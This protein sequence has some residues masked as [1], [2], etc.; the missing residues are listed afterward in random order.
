MTTPPTDQAAISSSPEAKQAALAAAAA[1]E[2]EPTGLVEYRSEGKVVLIGSSAAVASA[3]AKIDSQVSVRALL[4]SDAD[5]QPAGIVFEASPAPEVLIEGYLGAFEINSRAGR[6]QCDL[7]IDLD[8][9]PRLTQPLPPPGYFATR[10]DAEALAQAI[11]QLP[12]LVG[13]FDKPQYFRLKPEICAHGASELTGCTRCLDAC[14]AEAIFSIGD[15]VEVNPHLCQGG[16]VCATV[17]P[18]GAIS[19]AY[20][21]AANTLDRMRRMLRA[22]RDA[23]GTAAK[24]VLHS[25]AY[26]PTSLA[27]DHLPLALEE[28]ASAGLELW[29]S[30]LAFGAQRVL[31]VRD[32]GIADGVLAALQEQRQ[33]ANDILAGLGFDPVVQWLGAEQ[34]GQMPDIKAATFGAG[35]G[36]KREALFAAIDHL[37]EQADSRPDLIELSSGAP[38]GTV[39]VASG[40]T[41]CMACASVCPAKALADGDGVPALRFYESNCVQCGLCETAC[42]EQVI[43]LSPRLMTDATSRRNVRVLNEEAPFNCI[44]CSKP[45]ATRSVIDKMTSKLANHSMFQDEASLNRLK[46]CGDCRV[47]DMMKD[48]A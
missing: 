41:L 38:L 13:R 6:W 36:G 27:N 21:P 32:A 42:P 29:L 45:F 31:L 14:P 37:I 35:T 7:V 17:C 3:F 18:T 25:E 4:T 28:L 26:D 5:Q 20:P 11:E 12:D 43:S 46:M 39:Q 15:K 23:G 40:C 8:Q 48:D 16:G 9:T 2:A 30:A 33:V 47:I 24:L 34:T 10:G 22:Y 1:I 44:R 19:Y